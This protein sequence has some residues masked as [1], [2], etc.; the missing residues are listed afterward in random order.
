ML[1]GLLQ[2]AFEAHDGQ[3]RRSG[4]PFIIHPVEVARI[5]GE[6][7]LDWES[8]AAGLLH[9]T[10]EDTD[11]VTF[12]RI[13]KEFGA[14]VRHIV[15]VETKVSKLG[16]LQCKDSNE[17]VQDVK[18]DDLRQMFLAI[19]EEVRVIIVNLADRLHNMRTLS[20]M[21]PHKQSS[22]ALETL[23]VF[24]PLAKLLGMYQVKHFLRS[25]QHLSSCLF[26]FWHG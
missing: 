24:A 25:N 13:E 1:V 18:A 10:V 23:Q 5:L 15:E 12:E 2:L 22:I 20:H 17:S 9:D 11:V 7:E 6:L 8:I 4:E 3:K 19:T 21:P 26:P 14:T 16:K